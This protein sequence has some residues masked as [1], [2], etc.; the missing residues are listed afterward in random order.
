MS[1]SYKIGPGG[2]LGV[3]MS[4]AILILWKN[5]GPPE[6][7]D[8][9]A[10]GTRAPL[11]LQRA[12]QPAVNTTQIVDS[13][14]NTIMDFTSQ[15]GSAL[16]RTKLST[17]GIVHLMYLEGATA[18][19]NGLDGEEY[20][21]IDV[22]LHAR[23]STRALGTPTVATTRN[24]FCFYSPVAKTHE[25][26]ASETHVDQCLAALGQLGVSIDEP[27]ST[28]VRSGTLSGVV[29]EAVAMFDINSRE[30]EWTTIALA[31]YVAPQTTWKNRFGES[32]NFDDVA[33]LLCRKDLLAASCAGLHVID[34]IATLIAT[35][36][37]S[38][39][40]S[41]A[42][43]SEASDF[44]RAAIHSMRVTQLPSGAWPT[45]WHSGGIS[46]A[47]EQNADVDESFLVTAHIAKLLS[48][49]LGNP[50]EDRQLLQ[51]IIWLKKTLPNM[52]TSNNSLCP[53]VHA[54]QAI[55]QVDLWILTNRTH[56]ERKEAQAAE[57][58]LPS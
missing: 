54:I 6:H 7:A 13:G 37:K 53:S 36:S 44:L 21:C 42:I 29:K 55:R 58:K 40:L 25:E 30:I 15:V 24:G 16:R 11:P 48:E 31:K 27:V 41:D 32:H 52:L 43:A 45:N 28:E 49:Q 3:A 22:L 26:L 4:V 5:T 23:Q 20:R 9:I 50:G 19:F 34:A 12:G 38:R 17:S 18:K 10:H 46:Q 39:I 14:P 47:A 57:T 35:D 2:V 56:L 33:K 51:A 8:N 1:G